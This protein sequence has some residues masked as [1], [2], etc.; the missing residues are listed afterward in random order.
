MKDSVKK[1]PNNIMDVNHRTVSTLMQAYKADILIH[2]HTHKPG[3]H[4]VDEGSRSFT[5]IVLKDWYDEME[6]LLWDGPSY[7]PMPLERYLNE[8]SKAS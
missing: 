3:C 2:G 6:I 8:K 4:F 5:R 7:T 1:K